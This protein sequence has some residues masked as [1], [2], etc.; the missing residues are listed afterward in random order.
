VSGK[1]LSRSLWGKKAERMED[2]VLEPSLLSIQ[3]IVILD[4]DGE[5]LL[6]KYYDRTR[7]PN[8]KEQQKFEKRLHKKTAK[9]ASEIIM[10]DGLT[11]LYKSS[12]DLFFYVM[13]SSYENELLLMSALDVL[14]DSLNMILKKEFEKKALMEHLGMVMM[15][16]DEICDHGILLEHDPEVVV[17]RVN[18][19]SYEDLPL[20]EQTV[21]QVQAKF[22]AKVEQGTSLLQSAK[23]QLKWSL[24]K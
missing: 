4:C 22:Q 15:A 18:V 21:A 11:I 14:F 3:A 19:R 2:F 1:S 16:V 17:S 10:L 5:R 20:G 12:V 6:A 13:G 7:F 23:E 9:K 24:L 8:I